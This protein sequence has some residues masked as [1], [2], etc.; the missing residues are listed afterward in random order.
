MSTGTI[1]REYNFPVFGTQGGGLVREIRNGGVYK[2]IF[3]EAPDCPGLDVGDFMP[4]E[5]GICAA[6]QRAVD[7][8]EMPE[9]LDF[10]LFEAAGLSSFRQ[11]LTREDK[12]PEPIDLANRRPFP[13]M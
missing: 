4:E 11:S 5:W 8:V 12:K 7:E 13:F 6:N 1:Q 3:V 10:D 2:Y 9:E